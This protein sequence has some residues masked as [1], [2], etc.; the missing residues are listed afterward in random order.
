[1]RLLEGIVCDKTTKDSEIVKL[2]EDVD[3]H[4]A[5]GSIPMYLMLTTGLMKKRAMEPRFLYRYFYHYQAT[6]K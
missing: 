2:T 6:R 1:M 4:F 3:D 5:W